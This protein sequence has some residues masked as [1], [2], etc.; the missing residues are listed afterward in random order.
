MGC[1]LL[2]P[3]GL[4]SLAGAFSA[5]FRGEVPRASLAT[6]LSELSEVF[7]DLSP[8][9]IHKTITRAYRLRIV[10]LTYVGGTHTIDHSAG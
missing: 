8:I 7:C 2:G 3:S 10:L 9:H 1:L 4:G 6:L 5:L